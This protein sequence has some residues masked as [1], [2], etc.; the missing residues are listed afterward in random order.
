[1]WRAENPLP[2]AGHPSYSSPR[3]AVRSHRSEKSL[4]EITKKVNIFLKWLK[5][6]PSL[7]VLKEKN[8]TSSPLFNL[9]S[10]KTLTG[11]STEAL[12]F[13]AQADP[14]RDEQESRDFFYFCSE[15]R[16]AHR[17]YSANIGNWVGFGLNYS[18]KV[19]FHEAIGHFFPTVKYS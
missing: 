10:P 2:T 1:M 15:G 7:N 11:L 9:V 19:P 4:N 16:K 18:K 14:E 8:K 13:G 3:L 6:N 12:F 17:P 5:N